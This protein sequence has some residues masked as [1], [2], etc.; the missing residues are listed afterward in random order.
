DVAGVA[1]AYV[2]TA[3]FDPLIDEGKAYA[4]KLR[5]A[6]VQ[7]EYVCEEGLIHS[8][9]NMVSLGRSAP[10]AMRRAAAALQRG[11]S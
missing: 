4:D 3:G 10:R 9:A 6:G 8:F 7:V 5:D 2:V 1:P 11:L